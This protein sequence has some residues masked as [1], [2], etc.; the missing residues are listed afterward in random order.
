MS[1]K[2][3]TSPLHH[4]WFRFTDKSIEQNPTQV[5]PY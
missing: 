4:A 1:K 5:S 2:E 3:M